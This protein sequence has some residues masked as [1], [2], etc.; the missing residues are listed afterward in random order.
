MLLLLT[1]ALSIKLKK[2]VTMCSIVA[3]VTLLLMNRATGPLPSSDVVRSV[4]LSEGA[5][6]W[7]LARSTQ[8]KWTRPGKSSRNVRIAESRSERS[9]VSAGF[10]RSAWTQ[11]RPALKRVYVWEQEVDY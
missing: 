11:P 8:M 5:I 9:R 10:T 6:I 1:Q 4:M 3:E 7:P 2:P